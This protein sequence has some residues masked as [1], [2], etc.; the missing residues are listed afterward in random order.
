MKEQGWRLGLTLVVRWKTLI[1]LEL[2]SGPISRIET[3]GMPRVTRRLFPE[4]VGKRLP[5]FGPS[6]CAPRDDLTERGR[7]DCSACLIKISEITAARVCVRNG[8]RTA[9]GRACASL[10]ID[11]FTLKAGEQVASIRG[12]LNDVGP[13]MQNSGSPPRIPRTYAAFACTVE[14]LQ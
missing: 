6:K 2:E 9:C 7:R 10:G 4:S 8:E 12:V 3:W 14:I 1:L 5:I 11:I 13:R